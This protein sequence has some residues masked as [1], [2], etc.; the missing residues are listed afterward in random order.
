MP[1]N[2]NTPA[3]TIVLEPDK[4]AQ[5]VMERYRHAALFRTQFRPYQNVCVDEWLWRAWHSYRKVHDTSDPRHIEGMTSYYGLNQAKVDTLVAKLRYL[6]VNAADTPFTIEPTSDPAVP[7]FLQAR[8]REEVGIQLMGRAVQFNIP[9]EVLTGQMR[10][11]PRVKMWLQKVAD[12]TKQ[13][14]KEELDQELRKRTDLHQ[15]IIQGQLEEGN[16][17]RAYVDVIRDAAVY[18]AGFL[19]GPEYTPRAVYR[20]K[21]N[22]RV[23]VI[24]ACP[25]YRRIPPFD[26]YPSSDSSSAQDG[27]CFIERQ[28]KSVRDLMMLVDEPGYDRDALLEVVTAFHQGMTIDWLSQGRDPQERLTYWSTWNSDTVEVLVHQGQISGRELAEHGITGFD[29]HE[30]VETRIEVVG[31]RTIRAMVQKVPNGRRTAYS[32]SYKKGS[33]AV[34]GHSPAMIMYD[35]EKQANQLLYYAM[36]SAQK[37]RG[38]VLEINGSAFSDPAG[39]EE[40]GLEAYDMFIRDRLTTVTNGGRHDQAITPHT[41]GGPFMQLWQTFQARLKVAEEESG[42]YGIWGG[43]P[44]AFGAGK[45]LGGLAMIFNAQNT[46][47]QDYV[48]N[49]D[50][51]IVEPAVQAQADYNLEFHPRRK[52][53]EADVF[54]KARGA[55]GALAK[56]VKEAQQGETLQLMMQGAQQGLVPLDAAKSAFR[57]YLIARGA[58]P[59][60][61]P[62]PTDAESAASQGLVGA[63]AQPGAGPA[64]PAGIDRR[65]GPAQ[66]Q[67]A[68]SQPLAA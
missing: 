6:L 22:R 1:A 62:D 17:K 51:D 11:D 50:E 67:I 63:P 16:W 35:A 46:V 30:S 5:I 8:I 44:Q 3:D 15:Q 20:W 49:L 53:F 19:S 34:Y 14:Y 52:D 36:V 43:N 33:A 47:V 31:R 64:A 68:G 24:E 58:D 13:R 7:E 54:I 32:T 42:L 38:P 37:S 45:T 29:A 21:G 61:L 4:L 48:M 18:P 65:S 40:R 55:L 57:D 10:T 9:P 66:Q 12:A 39:I 2:P 23:K 28:R 25:N 59:D 41:I 60:E 56:E 27:Q 26:A